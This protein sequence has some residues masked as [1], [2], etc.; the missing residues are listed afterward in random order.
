MIFIL[1]VVAFLENKTLARSY[2]AHLFSCSYSVGR[3]LEF[4]AIGQ[5]IDSI[6]LKNRKEFGPGGS[7]LCSTSNQVVEAGGLL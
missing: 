7:C 5:T 1:P 6:S 4:R 3:L 2:G